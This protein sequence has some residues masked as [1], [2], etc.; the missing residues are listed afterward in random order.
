MV[1][2][3]IWLGMWTWFHIIAMRTGLGGIISLNLQ[4]GGQVVHPWDTNRTIEDTTAVE[5]MRAVKTSHEFSPRFNILNYWR[6]A[7]AFKARPTCL[8]AS[9]R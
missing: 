5:L 6:L 8:S 7:L 3:V 1:E 9:V 2:S 4:D